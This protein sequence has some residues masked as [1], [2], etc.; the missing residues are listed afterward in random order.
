MSAPKN[1]QPS[2]IRALS[3]FLQDKLV[4]TLALT[5]ENTCAFQY[6]ALWLEQGFS[7][8]PFSL[9][10][11]SIVR[12][13]QPR[14]FEGAQGIFADSLPDG[15][16]RLLVDR[17][18]RRQGVN[19]QTVSVLERL[20]IVGSSGMGALRYEPEYQLNTAPE[21]IRNFDSL[22]AACGD[23]LAERSLD[24]T[25]IL[26]DLFRAG[27]S[28]GGA[29]PKILIEDDGSDWI[30]KFPSSHDP[31]HIGEME[32]EYSVAA[33][34]CGIVMPQTKLFPSQQCGGYFGVERFDRDAGRRIHMASVSAL[35]E[36][37]H[38]IP[39]LDYISLVKL[40]QRLT[41]NFADVERL[42]TL[43][44]FNVFAHNHDDHSK[45]FSYVCHDGTWSLAPAYDLT[46]SHSFG[47]EH[48]TTI[49]G[50]GSPTMDDIVEVAKNAGI[51]ERK[52]RKIAEEVR[53]IAAP[54]AEKYAY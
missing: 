14:P 36:T 28:S 20:A 54:L 37:S 15:W 33:R 43:M 10:L 44:C 41:G 51:S 27:G 11:D 5:D 17:L 3:V 9:P 16:G 18:L 48:S 6:A 53:L 8:S 1:A 23:I 25:S 39:N 26:D 31:A 38:R 42:Y 21:A 52:G 46:Y 24:D 50:A 30:V 34:Q 12:V 19:P 13:A 45:N 32:Y 49:A 7:I 40:T 2:T 35:L 29:R 22:A 4:G 47:A